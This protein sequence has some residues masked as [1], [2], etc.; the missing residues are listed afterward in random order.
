MEG[1]LQEVSCF[2]ITPQ[3]LTKGIFRE[4]RVLTKFLLFFRFPSDAL[5]RNLNQSYLGS[6]VLDCINLVLMRASLEVR[7]DIVEMIHSKYYDAFHNAV[8]HVSEAVNMFPREEFVREVK[9]L[10]V[11]CGMAALAVKLE[12]EAGV[13]DNEVMSLFKDVRRLCETSI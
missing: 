12:E 7:S 10:A 2:N 5:F 4:S 11:F 13:S 9:R 3:T 8:I 6:L 1:P